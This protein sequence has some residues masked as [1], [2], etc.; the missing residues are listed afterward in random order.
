MILHHVGALAT[1]LA[2]IILLL[3]LK[4]IVFKISCKNL[5]FYLL[6]YIVLLWP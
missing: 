4:S 6:K 5:K 3:A 1:V 2:T